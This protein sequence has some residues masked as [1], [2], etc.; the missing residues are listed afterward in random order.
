VSEGEITQPLTPKLFATVKMDYDFDPEATC[1]RFDRFLGE[2]LPDP[3]LRESIQMMLGLLLLPDTSYNVAFFFLGT[4]GNGKSQLVHIAIRLVGAHNVCHVPFA[5]LEQKHLVGNLC[6]SLVNVIGDGDAAIP[7]DMSQQRFEG[8]F[9]N[10]TDGGLINLE[11]KFKDAQTH[12]ATARFLMAM[13]TLPPFS[14]RTDGVWD[15]LRIF[16]FNVRFRGDAGEVRGLGEQIADEELPGIF[17]FA[18]A[19][20]AKLRAQ[21]RFPETAAGLAVKREHRSSCDHEREFLEEGFMAAPGSEEAIKSMDLYRR[22]GEWMK[23]RGYKPRGEAQFAAAV[24]RVFPDAE[25]AK[26]RFPDGSRVAAWTG[27]RAHEEAT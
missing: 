8:V 4:G 14:D 16:P 7:T 1:P 15:R 20:L 27:I 5:S 2:L 19:G 11:P 6:R 13:N 3:E 12:P 25:K 9:K 18:V 23:D 26:Q 10:V 17:N 22:Y 21:L 24:R